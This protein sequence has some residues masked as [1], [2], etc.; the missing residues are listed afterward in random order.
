LLEAERKDLLHALLATLEPRRRAVIVAYE[1]EGIAMQDVA[2]RMSI[3]VNTAWNLLRLA[4]EDLRAAYC[5]LDAQERAPFFGRA[6]DEVG[7]LAAAFD[8][9]TSAG[10]APCLR[11]RVPAQSRFRART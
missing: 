11:S 8:E 7:I 10:R 5:R 9:S 1:L 6:C 4:R 2:A 3:S